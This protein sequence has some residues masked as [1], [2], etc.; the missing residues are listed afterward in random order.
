MSPHTPIFHK[1]LDC[2]DRIYLAVSFHEAGRCWS[3]TRQQYGESAQQRGI[4]LD[5][6]TADL[7]SPDLGS[8][9]LHTALPCSWASFSD[10]IKLEALSFLWQLAAQATRSPETTLLGPDPLAR[11]PDYQLHMQIQPQINDCNMD[12]RSVGTLCDAYL[13]CTTNAPVLP[14]LAYTDN[15]VG[16]LPQVSQL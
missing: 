10:D 16:S 2:T 5:Q 14:P 12:L 6:C 15:F 4:K 13:G 1:D 7:K 11:Y 9:N 3:S 8:S